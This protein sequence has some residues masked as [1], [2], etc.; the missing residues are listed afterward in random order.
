M[1]DLISI[2]PDL[3]LKTTVKMQN[4]W[5]PPEKLAVIAV[6]LEQSGYAA[7]RCRGMANNVDPD[8]AAPS[9]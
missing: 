1:L 3:L 2:V 7:K 8:Q 5:N 6:K 4:I 9:V